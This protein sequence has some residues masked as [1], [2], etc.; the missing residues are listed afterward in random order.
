MLKRIAAA[1]IAALIFPVIYIFFIGNNEIL[2]PQDT[3]ADGSGVF[4]TIY[5]SMKSVL[6]VKWDGE[7]EIFGKWETARTNGFNYIEA[8]AVN[9]YNGEFYCL[10]TKIN[11]KNFLIESRRWLKINFENS[12][13]EIINEKKYG[14]IQNAY[15]TSL[16]ISDGKMYT[17]SALLDS[18]RITD[19]YSG[20]ERDIS[21]KD[22]AYKDCSVVNYAA[23]LP[24]GRVIFSDILCRIYITDEK[25]QP[26][27]IYRA[28]AGSFVEMSVNNEGYCS[29]LDTKT[30]NSFISTDN[31]YKSG[32]IKFRLNNIGE[33]AL[34]PD[35]LRVS[36]SVFD[37]EFLLF[38]GAGLAAGLAVFV[39]SSLK[40][41]PVFLKISSIIVLCLGAGGTLLFV[42]INNFI[43]NEI[44]FK[45]HLEKAYISA[46]LLEAQID[47]DEFIKIDWS[48]PEKSGYFSELCKIMEYSSE[49]DEIKAVNEQGDYDN[50]T[51]SDKNY[52][53]IFPIV[54]GEIRSGICDQY[55]VNLPFE[56][57][58]DEDLLSEYEK[59][60]KGEFFDIACGINSNS[61]EWV[62]NI[63]PLKNKSGNIIAIIETGISKYNY[64]TA[65]RNNSA[66]MLFIVAVFE[67]VTGALIIAAVIMIL[68]PLKKLHKAV[69]D[70]GSGNYGVTVTVRGRDEIAGISQAFNAM[71]AQIYDHTRSLGE[72]NESYLRFFPSGIIDS[73][74]KTSVLSVSRGDYSSISSY[75]LHISLHDFSLRTEKLSN[76]DTFEL[77]NDLSKEIIENVISRSGIV[78]S[79]N[80][81]EYICVFGEPDPAYEAA[82][83]LI[84]QLRSNYPALKI[85][86][87]IIKD[88]VLL[89]IVGHEKRLGT[90]MLSQSIRLSKKLG[91]T[92]A[93]CGAN[94]IVTSDIALCASRPKRFLGKFEFDGCEYV[95][96]DC[97]EGD[98]VSVYLNK[99]NGRA[100]FEEMTDQFYKK[101]WSKCRRSALSYLESFNND[102]AAVK[103][104]F[105]SESNIK[106]RGKEVGMEDLTD[107]SRII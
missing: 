33:P 53:W 37:G 4:Y 102:P 93:L 63:Y 28:P 39:F 65:S 95:F 80:Q 27:L 20:K 45:S 64:M 21:L 2:V 43:M 55:P 90:I 22:E 59:V 5:Y 78:E 79:Y 101:E 19:V 73:I 57:V 47:L 89:G 77:I 58:A 52:L 16:A 84:R 50:I 12:S 32:K 10:L 51:F 66:K 62:I 36:G 31:S 46:V 91:K 18:I 67:T 49:S 88:S 9:V 56:K 34:E 61:S 74:G 29:I 107:F 75:I 3:V 70:A 42:I 7:S 99:L 104:L 1:V 26:R 71:S 97:F 17:V 92:A 25:D 105:L 86:F 30:E 106:N 69:E 40:R 68:M 8:E 24:D 35:L 15:S 96:Y 60:A 13:A 72:L 76:D 100:K 54:N 103:Y 82:I 87:V 98:E 11:S 83:S 6:L 85:S 48:A 23:S 41:V 38:C 94:L 14:K 81:E 44:H